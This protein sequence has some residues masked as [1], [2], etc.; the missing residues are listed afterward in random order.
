MIFSLLDDD[1]VV[2][3]AEAVSILED[4]VVVDVVLEEPDAFVEEVLVLVAGVDPLAEK[5]KTGK[6]VLLL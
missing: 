3:L 1:A 5:K 4:M 2:L 6:T